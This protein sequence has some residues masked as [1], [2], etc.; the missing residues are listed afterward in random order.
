MEAGRISKSTTCS[1]IAILLCCWTGQDG[2]GR[3][4]VPV[5]GFDILQAVFLL[6]PVLLLIMMM[7]GYFYSYTGL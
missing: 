1:F 3:M 4:D 5:T 6:L 7:Q 2:T